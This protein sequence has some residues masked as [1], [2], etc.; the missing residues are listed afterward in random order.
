MSIG[1]CSGESSSPIP[2]GSEP[3]AGPNPNPNPNPHPNPQD[4]G[5]SDSGK[6][7]AQ[8]PPTVSLPLDVPWIAQKPELPRGCE[9]TSLAM[10][11]HYAGTPAN[12]M[13]LAD[14]IVKVPYMKDGLHGNPYDGFVGDMYTFSNPGY[15][16]YHGPVARLAERYFP[17]RILDLT[18]AELDGLL[19]DHVARGR[20]VWVISNA[21]FQKL[22]PSDFETWHT[23][24]GDVS[25]T[26]HEHSVVITGFDTASVF[27]NDPLDTSAGK[28]K[29]LN[30]KDFREA[31]EQ[32]GKQAITYKAER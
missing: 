32:M 31:W 30:R 1:A 8:T 26:W 2:P 28:N 7:D 9:V 22:A 20:P 18:G 5:S 3:D 17:G 12:K 14:Q 29:K 21:R 13:V 4:A 16:V 27:I 25:I 11:L 10:L 19:T 23:A 6:A 15:G 24:S